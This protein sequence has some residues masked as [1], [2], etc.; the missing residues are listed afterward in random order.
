M[1]VMIPMSILFT[2]SMPEIINWLGYDEDI[3]DM[4][5]GFALVASITQI[6]NRYVI[7]VT[8]LIYICQAVL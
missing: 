8:E 1:I 6:I 5:Q 3:V 2:L 7:R 4:S